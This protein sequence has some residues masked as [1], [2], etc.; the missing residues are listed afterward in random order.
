MHRRA[1]V[2]L[3]GGG[4]VA[5]AAAPLAGCDSG[6]PPE[7]LAAWQGPGQEPDLRRWILGHAILAPHSH[8]LQSWLVDLR[9]P[10]EILLRCDL[11]RLL[12]ETDPFSRQIMMSQG[13][14]IELLDLAARERGQRAEITLF[15][16][17][18]FGPEKIDERPVARIRL[19]EDANV[20]KDPL[21]GQIFKRRT[22]RSAY[23]LERPVPAAA[24]QAMADAVQPHPLRFG[25]VGIDQPD[26]ADEMRAHREIANAAW[27]IELTT[28]RAM[29][30][31]YKVLR[32]G[33]A[34]IARHRDG[35]SL[36]DPMVVW[37][38]RLGLF[39]RSQAPG[40][41][42]FATTSQIKDFGAKIAS[43]PGFLWLVSRGN[44][45]ITQ[46]NAGRA[47]ARVQL[48][49]TA[50]GVAMHPLQQALQE[51]PE[52]ARPYAAIRQLLEAPAP[53]QTIQMWARVGFAP[54]VQ[55]A[56]RR[57]VAAHLVAG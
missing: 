53:T 1:F 45:R 57:G 16:E 55:P 43:T 3:V 22:N 48:A 28:P 13:T 56:P 31:S 17:G 34:E 15:P 26:S 49:G 40:P 8:N 47:Y 41:D 12:P 46:V 24:W 38:D 4:V 51:Y 20:S 30:E 33:A 9:T 37:M 14:F 42:D 10:G 44:D 21:F 2:R 6:L 11:E 18:E 23:E 25:F 19:V 27:R 54:P 50:Q 32:V 29:L 52:Q 7:A 39:D 36:T 5:A 35:L